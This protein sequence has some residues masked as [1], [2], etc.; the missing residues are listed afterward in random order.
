MGRKPCRPRRR[1]LSENEQLAK[2]ARSHET[3]ARILEDERRHRERL[4]GNN[5]S[6]VLLLTDEPID[7]EV[8]LLVEGIAEEVAAIG[9]LCDTL[10]DRLLSVPR[11]P[12]VSG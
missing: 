5:N 9:V 8:A 12:V 4:A 10:R 2:L 6:P 7:E 3:I 11:D 1:S